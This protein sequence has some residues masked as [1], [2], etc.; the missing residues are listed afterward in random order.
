MPG[1]P[2]IGFDGTNYLVVT[3]RQTGSPEGIIGILLTPEGRILDEFAI[4]AYNGQFPNPSVAF[5]G[6]NYLVVFSDWG[7]IKGVRVSAAG[8]VIDSN[9][10]FQISTGTSSYGPEVKFDGAQYLVVW[11]QYNGSYDIYGSLITP[12]AQVSSKFPISTAAGDQWSPALDFDGTNYFAVWVDFR[13]RTAPDYYSDIYGTRISTSGDIL[14][15]QGIPIATAE[16]YQDY[17]KIAFD[18]SNYLVVWSD[19][20]QTGNSPPIANIF[21]KRIRPDGTLMDGDPE[22]NGIEIN[23]IQ[24]GKSYLTLAFDGQDYVVAWIVGAYPNDPPAGI[25]GARVTPSG[26]LVDGPADSIGLLFYGLPPESSLLVHPTIVSNGTNS[27]LAWV[28]NIE[29]QA[30]T[31]RLEGLFIYPY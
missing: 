20:G 27:L 31:K 29:V 23:T 2:G 1:A 5:D 19:I 26:I 6:T 15:P 3:Y 11:Q 10:G 9:G 12:D 18:G 13:N 25:Y 17:P 22:T 7:V 14:D 16:T 28:V 30:A 24:L 4:A 8:S 21:G